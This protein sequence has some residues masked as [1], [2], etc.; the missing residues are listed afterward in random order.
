ML[1]VRYSVLA[2]LSLNPS[3]RGFSHA[4]ADDHIEESGDDSNQDKG[5]DYD[6]EKDTS[7]CEKDGDGDDDDSEKDDD[8]SDKNESHD[9]HAPDNNE[10]DEELDAGDYDGDEESDSPF[11]RIDHQDIDSSDDTDYSDTSYSGVATVCYKSFIS[12]FSVLIHYLQDIRLIQERLTSLE[13]RLNHGDSEHSPFD[14]QRQLLELRNYMSSLEQQST[15]RWTN[16]SETCHMILRELHPLHSKNS[17]TQATLADRVD[18][19]T[20][21]LDELD[22]SL[23]KATK[24][25]SNI[26]LGN[27][28]T[29]IAG[30]LPSE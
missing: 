16:I 14:F 2:M 17:I 27:K 19:L 8:D 9:H 4:E 29:T 20:Q 3:I 6:S 12:Q 26:E 30:Q 5:N 25:I 13:L 28:S 1:R 22:T 11:G 23:G 24:A 15:E 7:D 10:N 21:R 18:R